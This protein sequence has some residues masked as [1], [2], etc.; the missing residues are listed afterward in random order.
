[1]NRLKEIKQRMNEIN[2]STGVQ[3]AAARHQL[4]R[5]AEEDIEWLI[6]EVERLRGAVQNSIKHISGQCEKLSEREMAPVLQQLKQV[7]GD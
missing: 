4:D 1:M 2:N 5:F 7:I 6:E 3:K